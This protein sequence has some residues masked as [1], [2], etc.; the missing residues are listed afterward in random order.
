[1][2]GFFYKLLKFRSWQRILEERIPEPLH[3]NILSLFIFIF[4][5]FRQKVKF[6]L[7]LRFHH[8][9][10]LLN[11]ADLA[12]KYGLKRI[13]IIEFG[14]AAGAG[15]SNLEFIAMKVSKVTGI[16]I[17]IFGFDTAE[18]L[19]K[20][21]SYKD[22]PELY[23][24]GDLPMSFKKLS[25]SLGKN[26]KLIIGKIDETIKDFVKKD[27]SESPIAFIS[28]DVDYYSSSMSSLEVLSMKPNNYLPLVSIYLDDIQDDFHNSI[29]GVLG[30]SIDFSKKNE[31][32]IIEKN[33][34]LRT[35]RIFKNA[36]WI[37]HMFYAHILDHP[38]RNKL[39]TS[40]KKVI[41]ENPH[42]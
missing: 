3:L 24:E 37:D 18:G 26:T 39:T 12:K 22:H 23:A 28:I 34:F 42:I 30:A 4:G 10:A 19:P 16:E 17:D 27:F 9:Y 29:C 41:F 32:R 8:A 40:R 36:P 1:V 5:T 13:S 7:I 14:V 11:A 6:D 33:N 35:K 2:K 21:E 25:K 38:V 31:M 15:L 20:P